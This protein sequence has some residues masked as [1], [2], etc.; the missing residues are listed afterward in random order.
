MRLNNGSCMVNPKL[1]I[2]VTSQIY[3]TKTVHSGTFFT[4]GSKN[5]HLDAHQL[6]NVV[7][8]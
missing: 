1:A 3:N 7:H 5:Q 4:V 6:L 8:A 2:H